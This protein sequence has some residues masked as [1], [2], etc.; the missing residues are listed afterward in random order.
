MEPGELAD[1]VLAR[2]GSQRFGDLFP[3]LWAVA[4]D[5][6]PAFELDVRSRNC[7]ERAGLSATWGRLL[8]VCAVDLLDLRGFG[9][10][11]LGRTTSAMARRASAIDSGRPRRISA[12]APP[13][14]SWLDTVAAELSTWAAAARGARTVGQLL[15]ALTDQADLPGDIVH[16]LS[17]LRDTELT[18]LPVP[19]VVTTI[20]DQLALLVGLLDTRDQAIM[21]ERIVAM[22]PATL[23]ELGAA[24]G[25]TRERVRQLEARILQGIREQFAAPERRWLRWSAGR[26]RNSLGSAVPA[27]GWWLRTGIEEPLT[28]DQRRL[29]LWLAGPYAQHEGWLVLDPGIGP[30]TQQALDGLLAAGPVVLPVAVAAVT[31]LGV[32]AEVAPDWIRAQPNI[33]QS[34]DLVMRWRGTVVDKALA[35]LSIHGKPM[36]KVSL[37]EAIGE[38]HSVGTLSNALA[39]DPR[40]RRVGKDSYGLA[41]WG[42][43]A[44]STII[45]AIADE[46]EACG[47]EAAIADLVAVLPQRFGVSPNSVISYANSH[48]FVRTG[49]GLIRL[50]RSDDAAPSV[51]ARSPDRAKNCY[52]A[53]DGWRTRILITREHLRG[54]GSLLAEAFAQAVEVPLGDSRTFG[55]GLADARI[56]RTGMQPHLSS[57]KAVVDHFNASEG[58]LLFLE[59]AEQRCTWTVVP[60][61]E[62]DDAAG[63]TR[64]ALEVGCEPGPQARSSV[65]RA[66]GLSLH[67]TAAEVAERFDQRGESRLSAMALA[68]G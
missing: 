3:A 21:F 35:V 45:E 51:T 53:G 8:G 67:A 16:M 48:R 58:D 29:L 27:E 56:Y 17:E 7:L 38:G 64:L 11:S 44:Y 60:K 30:R 37:V 26:L 31:K 63:W 28:P 19:P 39:T 36:D 13:P 14:P 34:S 1:H 33:R 20:A 49:R 22:R 66:I 12:G 23:D 4:G 25:I 18:L 9:M 6:F 10:L 52:R 2:H 43:E 40:A 15:D 24:L 32:L 61:E 65:A 50:R 47:G 5:P 54:S 55:G 68:A 59:I 62:L 42:G 41:Q 46:V 57:V